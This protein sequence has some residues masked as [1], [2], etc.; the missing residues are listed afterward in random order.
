MRSGVEHARTW[1]ARQREE[2]STVAR[3]KLRSGIEKAKGWGIRHSKESIND[4]QG[5]NGIR[6]AEICG[7]EIQLAIQEKLQQAREVC[8]NTYLRPYVPSHDSDDESLYDNELSENST[9][10]SPKRMAIRIKLP[11]PPHWRS[12]DIPVA[13]SVKNYECCTYFP[14]TDTHFVPDEE[15]GPFEVPAA[16]GENERWFKPY[17]E[18]FWEFRS[19]ALDELKFTGRIH[20]RKAD[21]WGIPWEESWWRKISDQSGIQ[22]G[23]SGIEV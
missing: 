9:W 17:P 10:L 8:A 12:L 21:R 1:S 13:S 22:R 23:R 15:G 18:Q 11:L 6:G 3:K 7:R 16:R 4:T 20:G 2:R 19:S 5:E 14:E